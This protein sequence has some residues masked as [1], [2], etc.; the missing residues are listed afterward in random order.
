MTSDGNVILAQKELL[1]KAQSPSDVNVTKMKT[2][3]GSIT[4]GLKSVRNDVLT[5]QGSVHSDVESCR[6]RKRQHES[7]VSSKQGSISS[8]QGQINTCE[9]EITTH[10]NDITSFEQSAQE[11]DNR[12]G[13]IE[14]AARRKRKRGRF[15]FLGAAVGLVLAPVTGELIRKIFA[16]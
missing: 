6:S 2:S 5:M 3:L 10:Q 9:S 15:G 11:L 1:V 12:A 7:S 16:M 8:L 4:S 13:D 14:R